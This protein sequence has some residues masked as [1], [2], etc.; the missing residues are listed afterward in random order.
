[1]KP[2]RLQRPTEKESILI[3]SIFAQFLESLNL[4]MQEVLVSYECLRMASI[5]WNGHKVL[6]QVSVTSSPDFIEP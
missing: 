3:P 2:T 4:N 6:M 5:T 1:M